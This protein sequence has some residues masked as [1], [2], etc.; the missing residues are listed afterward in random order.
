MPPQADREQPKPSVPEAPCVTGKDVAVLLGLPV[1]FAF[2]WFVPQGLWPKL[3]A[4]MAGFYTRFT[5]AGRRGELHQRIRGLIGARPLARPA[6]Q[7]PA[8]VAVADL[9]MLLAQLRLYRPYAGL[10]QF[11]V[12]GYEHLDEA[13]ARGKGAVLWVGNFV[14]AGLFAKM[15]LHRAGRRVTHLSHP[16][17]GF[18]DSRFGMKFLNPV[19][20]HLEARYLDS[21]VV[22]NPANP[23]IAMLDLHKRLARN[24]VVSIT[25]RD[26]ANR[27]NDLPFLEGRHRLAPGAPE[28]AQLT[29]ARLLPLFAIEERPGRFRIR[30]EPPLDIPADQP[31]AAAVEAAMQA[32][33]QR[34]EP[35][36]L[37]HPDQWLG[38]PFT[39][40]HAR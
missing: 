40:D 32:Y 4:G 35:Y 28:M 23:I 7:I 34:L 10:P 25:V 33:L 9:R 2:A 16:K 1:L 31:R 20:T 26:Y 3:C 39:S 22:M 17:H 18:S 6:E 30:I 11:E 24:S 8:A 12:D 14:A 21:R 36:V 15:A 13:A 5:S 19:R 29:G 38:W 37:N 27:P